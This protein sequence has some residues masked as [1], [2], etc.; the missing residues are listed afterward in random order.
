MR[1]GNKMKYHKQIFIVMALVMVFLTCLQGSSKLLDLPKAPP[2]DKNFPKD[3]KLPEDF[4]EPRGVPQQQL[5]LGVIFGKEMKGYKGI[6]PLYINRC[7]EGVVPGDALIVGDVLLAVDGKVLGKKGKEQLGQAIKIGRKKGYFWLTRYRDG[8]I[9]SFFMDF[10][11]KKF[12]LTQTQMPAMTR[13]WR[14]GPL[15]VSGWCFHQRAQN[16]GSQDARQVIITAVD[17]GGPSNGKLRKN[18]VILGVSGEK[19]SSDARKVLAHGINEAEKEKNKG[20]LKLLVWSQGKE[21]N[22]EINLPVLGTY[23]K[24]APYDCPKTEKI[25]DH[26]V[27]YIKAHADELLELKDKGWINYITGLGLLATDRED[28]MPLVKKLAHDTILKPGEKLSVEKHV[29]MMCWWWSYRTL[30]LCEYYLKTKDAAVLSTIEEYATKLALGQS[31]AGTWGHTYAAR[32]NT[33][34]YH[35]HLGGYGAINQQGLTIMIGLP[36]AVKCGVKNKEVLDAIRRGT[37]F[38]SFFI[39]KGTIPYGDHGASHSSYDDNGK[40]GAAAIVFDLL[41]NKE[42]SSFFSEMVLASAPYGREDGHTGHFWSHL[43]GGLGVARG[44]K[45]AFQTYMKEMDYSFTLERQWDGR[46]GF[47]D[48]PGENG[49]KK[50]PKTRYDS[51]GARLLQLCL[52]KRAIYITG[53][54]TLSKGNL[55]SARMEEILDA[56]RVKY[57]PEDRSKLSKTELLKLLADPLPPTR[58]MAA[59]A[60]SERD[61]NCVKELIDMLDSENTYAK[62]GAAQALRNAGYANEE[63]VK[64]LTELMKESKDVTF[65]SYAINAFT[66]RNKTKGLL[67]A[68]KPAISVM[69]ELALKHSPNDPR[70]VL[71]NAIGEAL[72]YGGRAQPARGLIA[73]HGLPDEHRHLLIPLVKEILTNENGRVRGVMAKWVY[74]KL[75]ESER[76]QLWGYI[77]KASHRIAPSGI[78]FASGVRTVG[79]TL[80]SEHGVSEG[81]DLAAWYLRYQKGHGS[82]QRIPN[83]L[84]AIE[85]YGVHAKRIIPMLKSHIAHWEEN[86]RN[87]NDLKNPNHPANRTKKLILN[88]EKK[89]AQETKDL[90]SISNSLKELGVEF[91]P[92][93]IVI[94]SESSPKH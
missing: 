67:A 72:F 35:G 33:G 56:G 9:D 8:K 16:G 38:F 77:Y 39:G 63:A 64:K 54:E 69:M 26:A 24:T 89:T 79:L 15:G 61:I 25:I 53:K 93:P 48:N 6:H 10:G 21:H 36:L 45:L 59:S 70:K 82:H 52:P 49:P 78:M 7:W 13:D 51:T 57:S 60:I 19:F 23:S 18:D 81:L 68:G 44:G 71:Q 43:W 42:G 84:K 41:D 50:D 47:Q 1:L 17:E 55:S 5:P 85:G 80:M 65:Q 75:T 88:L 20:I 2:L 27:E 31:G 12:D 32:A 46:F 87:P 34:Y 66:S 73:E 74:P 30:F 94:S 40:S 91:P 76:A 29:S 86:V 22:I 83:A 28:V 92:K 4:K 58:S 90:L 14:L 62:Y 3:F 37:D 11:H